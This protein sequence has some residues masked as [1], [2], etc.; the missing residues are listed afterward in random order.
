MTRKTRVAQPPS[1]VIKVSLIDAP[2]FPRHKKGRFEPGGW[3]PGLEHWRGKAV[4][5]GSPV[6][7]EAEWTCGTDLVWPITDKHLLADLVKRDPDNALCCFFV[8]RHMFQAG[9]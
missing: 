4:L 1:A 6:K 2:N 5:L 3:P 8:C 9:D 7:P